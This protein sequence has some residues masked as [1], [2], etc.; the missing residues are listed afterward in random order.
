MDDFES[1]EVRRALGK[2]RL[3]GLKGLL[4]T[5]PASLEYKHRHLYQ[6]TGRFVSRFCLC[7]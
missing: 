7:L 5:S 3:L 6:F 1:I 2:R 4:A